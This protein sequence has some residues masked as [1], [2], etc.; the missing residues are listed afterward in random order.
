MNYAG[1][2]WSVSKAWVNDTEIAPK[3]LSAE[4][5]RVAQPTDSDCRGLFPFNHSDPVASGNRCHAFVCTISVYIRVEYEQ[6]QWKRR[7]AWVSNNGEIPPEAIE[8]EIRLIVESPR[9]FVE[10]V[11][12]KQSAFMDFL[13]EDDSPTSD[14]KF[15]KARKAAGQLFCEDLFGVPTPILEPFSVVPRF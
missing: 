10:K 9:F 15:E 8:N 11:R 4:I 6:Q 12:A 7:W 1:D 5:R 14:W 13:K 3:S 2:Q